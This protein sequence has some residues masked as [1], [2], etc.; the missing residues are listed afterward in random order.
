LPGNPLQR[1]GGW[2]CSRRSSSALHG[3]GMCIVNC[4]EDEPLAVQ[5]TVAKRR[6]SE[7]AGR[8]TED[9]VAATTAAAA[10]RMQLRRL[11]ER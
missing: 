5:A 6:F 10:L 1:S 3:M 9:K 4:G 11:M 8:C 2:A 7:Y